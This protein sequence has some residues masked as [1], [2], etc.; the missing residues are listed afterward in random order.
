MNKQTIH[1]VALKKISTDNA[2]GTGLSILSRIPSRSNLAQNQ[3]SGLTEQ[4]QLICYSSAHHP[5]CPLVD[6]TAPFQYNRH[7]PLQFPPKVK[8]YEQ[9]SI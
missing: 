1:F 6:A 9:I 4:A 3:T 8:K 5:P 2:N 7:P